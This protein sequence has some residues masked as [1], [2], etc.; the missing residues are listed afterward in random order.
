M[1][2]LLVEEIRRRH[3]LLPSVAVLE[4]IVRTTR[5]RA[6]AVV[7]RALTQG[8][9][10]Q[11]LVALEKLVEAGV[12]TAASRLAWLRTASRSPAARNLLGPD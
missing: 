6:E 8:L 9:S 4:L 11:T 5:R 12:A 10:G 7:Q 2:T 3:I 1:A